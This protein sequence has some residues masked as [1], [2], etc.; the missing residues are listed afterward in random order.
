[1]PRLV[2]VHD[3][4]THPTV[5]HLAHDSRAIRHLETGEQVTDVGLDCVSLDS[6]SSSDGRIVRPVLDQLLE[7]GILSRRHRDHT[8]PEQRVLSMTF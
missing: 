6:Q 8:R 5:E 1:M 4:D 3:L 2:L 7:H